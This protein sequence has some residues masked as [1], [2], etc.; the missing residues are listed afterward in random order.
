MRGEVAEEGGFVGQ[1]HA[2]DIFA[3][4]PD[5]EDYL[6]YESMWLCV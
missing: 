5:F 2:G 4:L 1:A 6:D 3:V